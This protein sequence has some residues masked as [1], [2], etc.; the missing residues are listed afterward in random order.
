MNN[1]LSIHTVRFIV[2]ILLQVLVF[3]NINFMG[4]INPYVYVLF[5]ALF[6]VKNNRLTFLFLSFLLGL[7]I[8][9]FMDSGGINAAAALLTAYARPIILKFSFG[10]IYE[11]QAVK[12]NN[13]DFGQRVTY[14]LLLVLIHHLT[15]FLLEIFNV[16]KI[17]FV[18]Q[19]T[20]FS[21]IFT[22]ILCIL[23]TYIF[24]SKSK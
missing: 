4:Y 14:I 12:F 23:I 9:I 24:S 22:I 13:I 5:I 10:A 18:L 6:P 7:S 3:N 8:D 20:L 16:S 2:L 11:H 15:Y 1:L 19:N 17:I 21:G